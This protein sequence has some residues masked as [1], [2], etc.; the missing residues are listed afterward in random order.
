MKEKG[1]VYLVAFIVVITLAIGATKLQNSLGSSASETETASA[2]V[3]VVQLAEKGRP[4][5]ATMTLLNAPPLQ[6]AT[7]IDRWNPE[8][9]EKSCL[10]C[11]S[12]PE[13]GAPTPTADHFY[14]NDTK[15]KVFRDNCVQCHAQQNDTKSKTA[16]GN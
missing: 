4:D 12:K 11:H 7:H 10:A 5:A 8:Q 3:N 9:H 2:T 6:P 13:T 1:I 15:G 14:E 16:F